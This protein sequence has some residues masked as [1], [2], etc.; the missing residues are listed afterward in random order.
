MKAS[1]PSSH[2]PPSS[3]S[4]RLVCPDLTGT[5][6]PANEKQVSSKTCCLGVNSRRIPRDEEE[7]MTAAVNKTLGRDSITDDES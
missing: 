6:S 1:V 4:A 2:N 3:S 5:S 7:M